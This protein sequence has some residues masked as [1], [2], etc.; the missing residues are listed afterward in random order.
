MYMHG[1]LLILINFAVLKSFIDTY[2]QNI[3]K[4]NTIY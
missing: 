1:T 4:V 3:Y 2:I